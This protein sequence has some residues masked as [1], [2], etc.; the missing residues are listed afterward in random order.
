MERVNQTRK[1]LEKDLENSPYVLQDPIG[2]AFT[3]KKILEYL[4]A[5][6]LAGE[7]KVDC[8]EWLYKLY[9]EQNDEEKYKF[10]SRIDLLA[11]CLYKFCDYIKNTKNRR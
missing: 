4:Y 8:K 9:E 10:N 3:Y 6:V 11:D 2:N 1:I 7:D 5:C